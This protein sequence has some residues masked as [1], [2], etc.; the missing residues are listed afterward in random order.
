[1]ELLERF[2]SG[3]IEAFEALFRQL[4][5]DVY[6]WIVRIVR[7]H[8]IAEDLTVE[9]FW[10]IYRAHARF[11]P[12]KDPAPW[13]RRIATNIALDYLKRCRPETELPA[14]LP[15]ATSPDPVLARE[16][17]EQIQ[18]AFFRLPPKLQIA[19]MLAL[20]EER[21]YEEIAEALGTTTGAVKLRVFRAVRILRKRLSHLGANPSWKTMTKKFGES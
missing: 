19:A 8:G 3:D 21:P 9:T 7:D 1:M 16:M 15:H 5:A 12:S 4:Q 13:A 6:G 14:Q 17:R 20:V 2:A 18:R 10:R 11:D